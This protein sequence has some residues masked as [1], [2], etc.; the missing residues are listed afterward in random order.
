MRS[1][2]YARAYM[3]GVAIPSVAVCLIGLVVGAHFFARIEPSLQRALVFPIVSNPPIWGVWNVLWVALGRERRL[4]IGWHGVVLS[5]VLIGAGAMAAPR[6]GL[7]FVTPLS[8]LAMLPPTGCV[9][10]V[11]WRYGVAFLNRVVGLDEPGRS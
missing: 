2:A 7:L 9:Y 6:L 3:A 1:H 8:A 10:Y 11:I 5:C 4:H